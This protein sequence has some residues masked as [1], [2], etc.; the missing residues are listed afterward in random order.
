MERAV[1]A[2]KAERYEDAVKFMTQLVEKKHSDLT[3]DQRNL[4]SVAFKNVVGA[5]RSAW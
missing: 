1:L 3:A 2:V 5:R 4:L